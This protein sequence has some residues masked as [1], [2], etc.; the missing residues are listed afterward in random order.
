MEKKIINSVCTYYKLPIRDVTRSK[1]RKE[2]VALARHICQYLLHIHTN[3]ELK[4]IGKLFNRK[5]P[6]IIYGIARIKTQINNKLDNTIKLD[7]EQ[8]SKEL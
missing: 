7:L 3:L 1:S 5:H 4:E 2:D 6:T 8:I